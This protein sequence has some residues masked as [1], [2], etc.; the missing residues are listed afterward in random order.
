M[1]R[2]YNELNKADDAFWNTIQESHISWL[3]KIDRGL[4]SWSDAKFSANISVC[5]IF[6]Y[7]QTKLH[8]RFGGRF[9]AALPTPSSFDVIWTLQ[10]WTHTLAYKL[11]AVGW[12]RNL[13]TESDSKVSDLHAIST[14]MYIKFTRTYESSK[15]RS[16]FLLGSFKRTTCHNRSTWNLAKFCNLDVS[17][18]SGSVNLS[19]TFI[20]FLF[21]HSQ[22]S[23]HDLCWKDSET[24]CANENEECIRRLKIWV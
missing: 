8:H 24:M 16:W 4:T 18:D 13:M 3:P 1:N 23:V 6:V 15:P 20:K 17:A 22:P 2:N 10:T 12:T 11:W 14:Q 7:V 21:S 19:E 5:T 9:Q